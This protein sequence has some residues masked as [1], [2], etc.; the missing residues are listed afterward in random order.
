MYNDIII[1]NFS[2]PKFVGDLE[3]ADYKFEIG[4]PVCGDR[5]HIQV[6]F[7]EDYIRE[8]R[9]RAWGCATSVATANIFCSSIIG[10]SVN[11]ISARK[12]SEISDMLGELEPSQ[13]HCINILS[14]LHRE[15]SLAV[16][17]EEG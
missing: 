14:E 4:N 9:F 12:N 1:D 16:S 8:S 15:L 3:S 17:L 5:I 10:K 13:Q 7:D 6:S 2:N 11:E